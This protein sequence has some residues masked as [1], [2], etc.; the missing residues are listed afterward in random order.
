MYSTSNM[1][2]C[3][4]MA[5]SLYILICVCLLSMLV[6]VLRS[7]S[8]QAVMGHPSKMRHRPAGSAG[9]A[10]QAGHTV[11]ACLP[12]LPALP[13]PTI[14]TIPIEFL[15]KSIGFPCV[16]AACSQQQGRAGPGQAERKSTRRQ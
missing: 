2:L 15:W 13:F 14:P 7:P 4:L 10:G 1:S 11:P 3:Y 5:M 12:A 9:Q 16:E 6:I 8:A